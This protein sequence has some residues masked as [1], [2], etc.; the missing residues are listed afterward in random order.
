MVVNNGDIMESYKAL[1]AN[2]ASKLFE[3]KS[4]SGVKKPQEMARQDNAT[5]GEDHQTAGKQDTRTQAGVKV[6]GK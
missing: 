4:K 5:Q 2:F 6:K 1:G 3:A